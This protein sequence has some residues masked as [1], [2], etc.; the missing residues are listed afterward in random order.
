MSCG[1]F[2]GMTE[3][4]KDVGV[5]RVEHDGVESITIDAPNFYVVASIEEARTIAQGIVAVL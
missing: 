4:G 2:N 1:Q 3:D 5:R